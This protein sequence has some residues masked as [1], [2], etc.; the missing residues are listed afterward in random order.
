MASA[1][2]YNEHVK[3]P[4]F[5]MSADRANDCKAGSVKAVEERMGGEIPTQQCVP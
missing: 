5:P 1:K 4:P 2:V 3:R